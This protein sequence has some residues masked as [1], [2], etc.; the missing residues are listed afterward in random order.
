MAVTEFAE[1]REMSETEWETRCNLAAL[2]RVIDR[3]RWTDLVYTHLSARVPDEES[4]FLINRYGE[5]FNEVTASSLVKMDLNGNVLGTE[6]KYNVAGFTIHSAVYLARPDVA[7][8]IHLHTRAS[9]AVAATR[10]GLLPI[11]QHS[12][13]V[14]DDLAYHDYEGPAVDLDERETLARDLGDKNCMILR[15][16]GLLACGRTIPEAFRNAYYL[17]LSCQIQVAAQSTGEDLILL[18]DEIVNRTGRRKR[19][20]FRGGDAGRLEWEALLR[21]LERD[22]VDYQR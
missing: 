6:G 18:S 8:V 1:R 10:R 15:N 5:M 11:S 22:G 12:L 16:H 14:Y 9:I 2:Y 7:C 19:E 20:R 13:Y 17:E 3:L 4:S 21:Q